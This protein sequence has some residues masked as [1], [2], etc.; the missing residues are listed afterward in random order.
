MQFFTA[1]DENVTEEDVQQGTEGMTA[2]ARP[3]YEHAGGEVNSQ[4]SEGSQSQ[5][6]T[7]IDWGPA[8]EWT[9]YESVPDS[10][11]RVA[12][13]RGH[14]SISFKFKSF[15]RNNRRWNTCMLNYTDSSGEVFHGMVDLPMV[16]ECKSDESYAM[17]QIKTGKRI[18]AEFVSAH[19]PEGS[20][21]A[22]FKPAFKLSNFTAPEHKSRL[23]EDA[24]EDYCV[25]RTRVD[26]DWAK[27]EGDNGE[28]SPVKEVVDMLAVRGKDLLIKATV[29]CKVSKC[30]DRGVVSHFAKCIILN[31]SI[32]GA[33]PKAEEDTV[34]PDIARLELG[35]C[36]NSVTSCA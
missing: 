36:L 3:G 8:P 19:I 5:T 16:I 24:V 11:V 18:G 10:I 28:K 1:A 2:A 20:Y 15:L 22:L 27:E 29:K 17:P 30:N 25:V 26:V 4:S 13:I 21:C 34:I 32:V 14:S 9:D 7:V 23:L 6:A 33:V 12:E 35:R 31:A